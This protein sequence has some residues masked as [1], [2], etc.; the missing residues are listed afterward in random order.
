[1]NQIDRD[2]LAELTE[3]AM[4]MNDDDYGSDR[5]VEAETKLAD[6]II[7]T[8]GDDFFAECIEKVECSKLSIDESIQYLQHA[9]LQRS[10]EV[11]A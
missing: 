7:S 1:M 10:S 8:L 4:P 2:A 3:S 11:Q 5:Q 9:T 6:Y